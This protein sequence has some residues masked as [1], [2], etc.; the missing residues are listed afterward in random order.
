MTPEQAARYGRQIL[1]AELGVEGQ[2]RIC[3]T[4][5]PVG[6]ATFAHEVAARYAERAG[7]ASVTPG[8]IDLDALAPPGI[9]Q[10]PEARAVLAAARVVLAE[11]RKARLP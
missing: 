2:A 9:V 7:F 6:G 3:A 1:L 5:A 8:V 10:R 11:M 4:T